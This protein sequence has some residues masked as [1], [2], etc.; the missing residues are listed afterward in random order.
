[1]FKLLYT[2]NDKIKNNE[3]VSAINSG[4]KELKEEIKNMSSELKEIG[5]P[6]KI[7]EIVEKIL[8]FNEQNQ[9]GKGLK[10]LT[11]NQMLSRLQITLTQLK[12]GDNSEKL[13]NEIRQ[14]LHSLYCSKNMTKQVYKNLVNNI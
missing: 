10:I 8:E 2:T 6:D 13:K 11:P 12:A 7:V 4:L 1:M 3:L 9:Q 5:K 14:L